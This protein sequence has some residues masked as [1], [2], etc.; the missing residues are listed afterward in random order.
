VLLAGETDGYYADYAGKGA[1][2]M[3][4]TLAEGY[5][6]QA[7]PSPFRKGEIRGEPSRDLPPTTMID[8]LQNHDQIG[9]RAMGERLASLA[10]PEALRLGMAALLLAPAIPM[11]FQGEEFASRTPFLFFCD[12]HGDLATAVREGRRREFA[13]FERFSDP[14][15]REKI[16]D[17]NARQTFEASKLQ[18]SDL[19]RAPHAQARDHTCHLLGVRSRQ[20]APRL[21]GARAGTFHVHGERG[22]TVEWPLGGGARLRLAANF[23]DTPL[24]ALAP[25]VGRVIHIE[26]DAAHNRL[27]PWSGIWTLEGA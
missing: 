8:F 2:F 19:G 13:A 27:G 12:F 5:A 7:D 20:I 3:G 25:P 24:Q 16:P 14:A 4:R 22:L 26:G 10:P 6:Y 9:N 18:W 21:V 15:T 1:W 11:L 17:P 23:G